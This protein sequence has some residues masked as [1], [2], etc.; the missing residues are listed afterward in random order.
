ML[1]LEFKYPKSMFLIFNSAIFENLHV[2]NL[3][4]PWGALFKFILNKQVSILQTQEVDTISE[5][6][7]EV[8]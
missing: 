5:S 1:E 6:Q 3:S 2:Q 8:R 7:K 4:L